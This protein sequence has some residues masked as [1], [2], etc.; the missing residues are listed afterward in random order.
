MQPAANI[1]SSHKFMKARIEGTAANQTLHE[2]VSSW[3]INSYFILT[4]SF[5][6]SLSIS[7]SPFFYML[8]IEVQRIKEIKSKSTGYYYRYE[9]K[10]TGL[11]NSSCNH[12]KDCF[13]V[14]EPCYSK[15]GSY[16]YTLA[17]QYLLLIRSQNCIDNKMENVI[18]NNRLRD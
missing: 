9:S 8:K 16:T 18:D 4:A 14:A 1:L 15:A 13:Q 3:A 2:N 12:Q 10:N 5:Q 6:V 7:S 17:S 11:F